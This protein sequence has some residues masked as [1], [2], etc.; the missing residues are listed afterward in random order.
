M[1]LI[2]LQS[3]IGAKEETKPIIFQKIFHGRKTR[4]GVCMQHV[5]ARVI[6]LL[7]RR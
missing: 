5:P 3:D 6:N 7:P 2:D 4:R 1:E